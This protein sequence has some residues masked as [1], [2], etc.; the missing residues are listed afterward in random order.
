[1]PIRLKAPIARNVQARGFPQFRAIII[2]QPIVAIVHTI[3]AISQIKP[4]ISISHL[5]KISI[6]LPIA[7]GKTMGLEQAY[8]RLLMPN[9]PNSNPSMGEVHALIAA[10]PINSLNNSNPDCRWYRGNPTRQKTFRSQ[11]DQLRYNQI[12]GAFSPRSDCHGPNSLIVFT[13][14]RRRC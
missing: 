11:A 1:M 2:A 14:L 9:P 6:V 13:E 3:S 12:T 4:T 5:V 8:C 7:L 10:R